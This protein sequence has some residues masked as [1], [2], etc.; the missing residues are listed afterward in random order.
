MSFLKSLAKQD[1]P[2]DLLIRGFNL[3]L[4]S[5][6]IA[7]WREVEALIALLFGG[8]SVSA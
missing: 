2:V 7:P 4:I 6:L 1:E 5:G 3:L 8:R